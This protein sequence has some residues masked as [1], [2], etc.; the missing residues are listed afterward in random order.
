MLH[1]QTTSISFPEAFP[2]VTDLRGAP[3]TGAGPLALE[4]FETALAQLNCYVG[5]PVATVDQA[6]ADSPDFAI[7]HALKS[8]LLL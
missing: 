4:L 3:V 7:G 2:M 8:Y 6:L 1:R 5:D